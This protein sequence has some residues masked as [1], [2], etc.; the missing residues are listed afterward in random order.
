V[1]LTMREYIRSASPVP[2]WGVSIRRRV[3]RLALSTVAVGLVACGGDSGDRAL[4]ADSALGRDLALAAQDSVMPA[5]EDVP[6]AAEPAQSPPAATPAPAPAPRPSAQRPAPR[7]TTPEA[8]APAPAPAPEPVAPA[9][10]TEGTIASGTT[11]RFVTNAQLCTATAK[12]GDRFTA[13]L[14]GEATGSNGAVVPAGSTG[15]FEVVTAKRA[16]N[17]NDDTFLT[18]R[19]VSVTVDGTV[20]PVQ[21]TTQSAATERVRASTQGNDAKKVAGGAIAGAIA[22]RVLGG[23]ARGAVVGAAAGAAAGTAAAIGTAD[24]DTCLN[25]GAVIAV[26][27]TGPV[28]IRIAG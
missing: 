10:P 13:R 17:Q 16:Q 25:G 3:T 20:Y 23:N 24:W 9:A 28:T 11:M 7:P 26:S 19:L 6:V 15:T 21:A 8:V 5:L 4:E 27:L 12:A 1:F 22:G 18:V 2:T 14:S